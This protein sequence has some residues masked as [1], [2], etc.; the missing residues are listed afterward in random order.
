MQILKKECGLLRLGVFI[1]V[2][3]ICTCRWSPLNECG[4]V[5]ETH[6]Y[7]VILKLQDIAGVSLSA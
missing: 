5:G 1:F 2:V 3:L 6:Q 4:W 7:S